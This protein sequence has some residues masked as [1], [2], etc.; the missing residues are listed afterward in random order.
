MTIYTV[1]APP[2]A[3]GEAD[4]LRFAF[5]KEGL[6]WPAL[7]VPFFWLLFRRIWVA[8]AFYLLASVLAG[9]AAARELPLLSAG[10]FIFTTLVLFLEGNSLRRWQLERRGY[11]MVGVVEGAS[12]AEAEIRFFQRNAAAEMPPPSPALPPPTARPPAGSRILALF[13][14]P[15]AAR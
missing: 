8:L 14:E 12:R 2:A 7:I 10:I 6:C 11:R 3:G 5:V 15:E 9:F 13:P 4:P 1:Q